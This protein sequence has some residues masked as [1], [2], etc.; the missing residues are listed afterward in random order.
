MWSRRWLRVPV[1]LVLGAFAPAIVGAVAAAPPGFATGPSVSLTPNGAPASLDFA[2]GGE[3]AIAQVMGLA[4]QQLTIATSAGTFAK[5]CDVRVSLRAPD[6]SLL[7]GPACV[8]HH[9]KVSVGAL[10]VDGLYVVSWVAGAT[11]TGLLAVA[12][13]STG[14]P[15]SITPD[16]GALKV[17]WLLNTNE[18]VRLGFT[19]AANDIYTVVA[20]GGSDRSRCQVQARFLDSTGTPVGTTTV[21][22]AGHGAFVDR[23]TMPA[24]GTYFVQLLGYD[25]KALDVTLYKVVDENGPIATDGTAAG[26][27]L[28]TPGQ[29]ARFTFGAT[30]GQRVAVA[31]T[32][33]QDYFVKIDLYRP[34]G[35]LGAENQSSGFLDAFT[36]D[37]SGSWT[38]VIDPTVSNL[39]VVGTVQAWTFTDIAGSADLTGAPHKF[40][41]VPGQRAVLSFAGTAGQRI[42]AYLAKSAYGTCGPYK[43]LLTLHRPDGSQAAAGSCARGTRFVD[44]FPLDVTGTWAIVIDPP[45]GTSG[46]ATLQNYDVVDQTGPI[47]TDGSA[48][49]IVITVP[50]QNARFTFTTTKAHQTETVSLTDSTFPTCSLQLVHEGVGLVAQSSCNLGT[51]TIGPVTIG[52]GT[53]DVVFDPAGPGT[54]SATVAV[55]KG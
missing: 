27:D 32:V 20:T 11:A 41:L 15:R 35:S 55:T 2:T 10:P 25:S 45:L 50:G 48:V 26:L 21:A 7:A 13:T 5:S 18:D 29:Q 47:T 19:S 36:L 33:P 12:A 23:T 1:L 14:G 49:P 8:G 39:P 3:T 24:A 37:T 28:A 31:L 46:S 53:Y 6:A 40:N 38:I 9:G 43:T 4:G 30:A 17:K 42:S 54:G 22:C 34:D 44:A 16:A 52:P 51:A